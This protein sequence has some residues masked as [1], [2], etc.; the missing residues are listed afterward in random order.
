MTTCAQLALGIKYLSYFGT[1]VRLFGSDVV[2]TSTLRPNGSSTWVHHV[3][4]GTPSI[5][6]LLF[7]K[8][9]GLTRAWYTQM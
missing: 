9:A 4:R 2:T 6:L 1:G 5:I 8:F 3:P 7:I